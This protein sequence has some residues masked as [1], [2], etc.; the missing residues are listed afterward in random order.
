MSFDA[1][2]GDSL[3]TNFDKTVIDRL[4]GDQD[5]IADQMPKLHKFPVDWV[6][7][8]RTCKKDAPPDKLIIALCMLGR[9]GKMK[10]VEAVKR[11]PW[12]KEIW[13]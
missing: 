6:K 12:V 7:K 13:I 3:F 9:G 2:V 11:F 5:W 8:L 10:N 1:G 4:W